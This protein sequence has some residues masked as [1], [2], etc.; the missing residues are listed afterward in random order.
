[1]AALRAHIA[2]SQK[3]EVFGGS[4]QGEG[5]TSR[6]GSRRV[7]GDGVGGDVEKSRQSATGCWGRLG[8]GS[9]DQGRAWSMELGTWAPF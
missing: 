7:A 8:T 9:G 5:E 1:M 6:A 2:A 3:E 4:A